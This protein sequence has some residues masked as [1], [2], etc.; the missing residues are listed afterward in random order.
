[1]V[2]TPVAFTD[3]SHRPPVLDNTTKLEFVLLLVYVCTVVCK[4]DIIAVF[5]NII[6]SAAYA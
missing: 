6:A 1:M 4:L 2:K 3:T 5:C